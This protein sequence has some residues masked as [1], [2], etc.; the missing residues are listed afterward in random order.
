MFKL[1][2]QHAEQEGSNNYYKGGRK[3]I[4]RKRRQRDIIINDDAKVEATATA[5]APATH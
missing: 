4:E 3:D 2:S 5:T 1:L